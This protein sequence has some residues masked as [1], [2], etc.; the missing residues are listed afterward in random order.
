MPRMLSW[1]ALVGAF[2]VG[3]AFGMA[4]M[5]LAFMSLLMGRM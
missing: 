4:M 1:A 3:M 2:I 5:F